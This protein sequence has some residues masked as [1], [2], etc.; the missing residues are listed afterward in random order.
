M[1]SFKDRAFCNQH[2][3]Q[4]LGCYRKFTEELQQE[5]IE[6]WGGSGAPVAFSPMRDT[7][8]CEGYKDE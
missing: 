8:D 3:C 7:E 1:I 2:K 6:W 4:N 5:S